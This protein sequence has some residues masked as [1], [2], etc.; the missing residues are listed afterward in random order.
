VKLFDPFFLQDL[1]SLLALLDG[2]SISDEAR[3]GHQSSLLTA[4]P[5]SSQQHRRKAS[6]QIVATV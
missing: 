6:S 2:Q 5:P 4:Q 3:E 1:K